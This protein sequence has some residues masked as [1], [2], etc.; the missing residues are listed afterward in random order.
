MALIDEVKAVCD[1]LAPHGW[2]ELLQT[3]GLDI[4]VPAN[5]LAAELDKPLKVDRFRPGFEDFVDASASG[6]TT[7]GVEPGR[8]T[9]SLL[10]HALAS[11][12]V[13]HDPDGIKLRKFPTLRQIEIVENYV[14]AAAKESLAALRALAKQNKVTLAVAVFSY[15]YRGA[16]DTCHRRYAD[17]VF[18]RTGVSRVG[19]APPQYDGETRGFLPFDAADAFAIRVLPARYAAFIAVKQK[20]DQANFCPMRFLDGTDGDGSRDFWLPMHKLFPG[21]EC[22][23]DVKPLS[24]TLNA[25]HI[26]EKIGRIHRFLGNSSGLPDAALTKPPFVFS[27]GIAEFSPAASDCS[28]FLVPVIHPRL[29][30]PASLKGKPVSF[31]VPAKASAFSSTVAIESN[32]GHQPAPEYVNARH[33]IQKALPDLNLNDEPL[34]TD[35]LIDRVTTKRDR[36]RHFIDFTGDG[37]I[38]VKVSQPVRTLAGN[39]ILAAYSLVAPP[40]FFPSTD[41]R[42][43]TE[44][45]KS[46]AVPTALRERIWFT[47]PDVLSDQRIAPNLQLPGAPFAKTDLT[48]TAIVSMFGAT[49]PFRS[50]PRDV[51]PL[52]HSHLPDDSA[53]VFAPGWDV[54]LDQFKGTEHLA[55][56]SLGSPFPE[57]AKLCAAL[58]TFWPAAAPD[59]TRSMDPPASNPGAFTVSPL[60]DEEIGRIGNRPWDGVMGPVVVSEGSQEFVEYNSFAHVD[61]VDNALAG[62]F[63]MSVLGRIDSTEYKC[64]VLSSAFV[65]AI[66]ERELGGAPPT[67]VVLSFRRLNPGDPDQRDAEDAAGAM[68]LGQTYRFEMFR[69]NQP[70][71]APHAPRKRRME[72]RDRTIVFVDPFHLQLLLKPASGKWRALTL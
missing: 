47:T 37:A 58:A 28:G 61:Y 70:F 44:W 53:G 6:G 1:D 24:V 25:S 60:T 30:E 2:R 10:Y 40:D 64:R 39:N 15:E 65:H 19:T 21:D 26:N 55:A 32:D 38:T 13:L 9:F 57:D 54:G 43:L 71:D 42:E 50:E 56:Y 48:A 41:Q 5:K 62:K 16:A 68:L 51:D 66:L 69:K 31:R 45:G 35:E 11:P 12:N 34:T 27:D 3:H 20:G 49:S 17:L 46:A 23:T 36:V 7:R 67:W 14:F 72:L 63:S 29:V 8:P 59:G 22:L 18:A 4:T 52:R 33:V